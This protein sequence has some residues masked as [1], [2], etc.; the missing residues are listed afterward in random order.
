MQPFENEI[1][2]KRVVAPLFKWPANIISYIFHPIFIPLY[3][4]AFLVY[5]HPSFFVGFSASGKLQTVFITF[6]N[7]VAFPLLT[8]VL[9]KAL[10]F[11]DS[12]FLQS[13][14]D[15]IIPYMACGIFFF[16]AY[17]VFKKEGSYPPVMASFILGVFLTASAGLLANIYFKISMHA[18][19]VG[20]LLGLFM[21]LAYYNS[22]LMTWPLALAFILAGL[23]C[24]ARLLVS[25]H[26]E[27]DI[28][29]G[30]V[31][32]IAAQIIAAAV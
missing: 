29:M 3:A 5:V 1:V 21:V 27:R 15:R 23:V 4:V 32:G 13:R 25:S 30:I 26:S 22:M 10:G 9:L 6:I 28:Y 17:T 11:I 24:T 18:M 7:L 8:V 2:I 16:W 31:V 20:G 12:V 14:R 19:G